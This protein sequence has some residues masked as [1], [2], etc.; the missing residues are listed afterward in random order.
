[1][2]NSKYAA[3]FVYAI[4]MCGIGFLTIALLIAIHPGG[5]GIVPSA[6]GQAVYITGEQCTINVEDGMSITELNRRFIEGCSIPH[7]DRLVEL[8]GE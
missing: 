3:S 6:D 4:I 2:S 5:G 7:T 8:K 1:M